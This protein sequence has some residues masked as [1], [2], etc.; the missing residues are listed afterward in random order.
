MSAITLHAEQNFMP[1]TQIDELSKQTVK[2]GELTQDWF[3][4]SVIYPIWNR[5]FVGMSFVILNMENMAWEIS[6]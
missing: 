4:K 6:Y 5:T 1:K 3:W 2:I